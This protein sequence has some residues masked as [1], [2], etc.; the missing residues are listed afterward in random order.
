MNTSQVNVPRLIRI[1]TLLFA[2]LAGALVY[3]TYEPA[4]EALGQRLSD[5]TS[6]LRSDETVLHTLPQLRRSRDE[7]ARQYATLFA[8]NPEAVFLRDLSSATERHGVTLVSTSR[9]AKRCWG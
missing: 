5:D 9:R 6:T 1:A 3:L 2:I 8:Q 7:L 4:A